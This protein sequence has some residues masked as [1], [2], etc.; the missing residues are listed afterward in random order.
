MTG[1]REKCVAAG[2]DDYIAKPIDR[3]RLIATVHHYWQRGRS[4]PAA[5]VGELESG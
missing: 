3:A 5:V 2:C 4:C 1:D